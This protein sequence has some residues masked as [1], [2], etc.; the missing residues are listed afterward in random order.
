MKEA[1]SRMQSTAMEDM[2]FQFRSPIEKTCVRAFIRAASIFN[3]ILITGDQG[4]QCRC[5]C[6]SEIAQ[7][8]LS[9]RGRRM[10][11]TNPIP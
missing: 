7:Y 9:S 1:P 11:L 10:R 8:S 3:G 4:G 6:L 2:D 5:K